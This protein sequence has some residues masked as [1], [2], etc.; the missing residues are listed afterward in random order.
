M[1]SQLRDSGPDREIDPAFNKTCGRGLRFH[2]GA[3]VEKAGKTNH[4]EDEPIR[5][6]QIGSSSRF[7]LDEQP[8]QLL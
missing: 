5:K 4:R 1:A 8:S 6:M 2:G 7:I 3:M